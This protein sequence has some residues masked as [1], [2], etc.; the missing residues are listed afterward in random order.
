MAQSSRHKLASHDLVFNSRSVYNFHSIYIYLEYTYIFTWLLA[1]KIFY[2]SGT[3]ELRHKE[4][5][6]FEPVWA[7]VCLEFVMSFARSSNPGIV[8]Q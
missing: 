5:R 4:Q 3:G 8:V 2:I 7:A 1:F 6:L